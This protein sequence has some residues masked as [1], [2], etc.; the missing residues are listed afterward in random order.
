LLCPTDSDMLWFLGKFQEIFFS[1][2]ISLMTHWSQNNVLFSL[3][4]FEYFLL[5]LWFSNSSFIVL[6]SDSIQGVI[7][8]YLYLLRHTL[9]PNMV[10]FGESSMGFWEECILC[11][12]RIEYSFDACQVHLI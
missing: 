9:W 5:F 4:V 2:L 6:C 7:S 10:Y 11:C 1:S 3:Q 8:V 12:F